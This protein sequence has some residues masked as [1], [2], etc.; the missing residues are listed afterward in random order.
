MEHSWDRITSPELMF[1]LAVRFFGVFIV[2][3]IVMIGIWVSGLIFKKLEEAQK[4]RTST[5]PGQGGA[6]I[7]PVTEGSP[8]P[9]PPEA[10]G[11]PV[12]QEVAAVIALN[13]QEAH[14]QGKLLVTAPSVPPEVAVAISMA[15]SRYR[16]E[17]YTPYPLSERPEP[18][19]SWRAV[20]SS[21][22]LLGRQEAFSRNIPW[23][24]IGGA[25]KGR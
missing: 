14:R 13:V 2:L 8:L 9:T 22:R 17:E 19:P 16:K 20:A 7:Q 21:W 5:P 25:R 18:T 6:G 3:I 24:G 1:G 15:V 10:S 12:S 11:P 23:T 4:S